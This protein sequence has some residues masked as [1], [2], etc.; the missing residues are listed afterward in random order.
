MTE[1]CIIGWAHSPFGKLEDPD[2]EALIGR[3]AGAA[4]EDAGIAPAR[5]RGE[6]RQP[7]QQG[8]SAQ[9]FPASLVCSTCRNCASA[10]S[11]ATRTRAPRVR[12]R[13][14][15]HATSWRPGAGASRWSSAWRR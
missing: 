12:R 5:D 1:A 15:A 2:I 8:F 9:D 13:C 3:V 14:M 4:I 10:R 7:V 11:R 6:L